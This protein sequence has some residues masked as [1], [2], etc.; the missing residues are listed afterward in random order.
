L[1]RASEQSRRLHVLLLTENGVVWF[2]L[3]DSQPMFLIRYRHVLIVVKGNALRMG[4][5]SRAIAKFPIN[6]L[7]MFTF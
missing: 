4:T 2:R 6:P 5:S 7:N 1:L 3:H